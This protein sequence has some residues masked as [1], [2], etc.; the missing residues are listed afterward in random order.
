MSAT[1]F[2]MDYRF[3]D[4][5]NAD[6]LEPNDLIELEGEIVLVK[7]IVSLPKGYAITWENEFGEKDLTE[8]DDYATF[9]L[10]VYLD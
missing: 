9:N 3:V 8:V 2:D 7:A 10:Y 1:I 4:T 6:Q 5:L